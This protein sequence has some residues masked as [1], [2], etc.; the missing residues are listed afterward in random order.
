MRSRSS[1]TVYN[2]DEKLLKEKGIR[3]FR[4]HGRFLIHKGALR[5]PEGLRPKYGNLFMLDP[6]EAL[7]ERLHQNSEGHLDPT[8]LRRLQEF[9][10]RV[11]PFV[12]RFQLLRDKK[13]LFAPYV[14][15]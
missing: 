8:I 7:R 14:I 15:V 11:N 1:R 4:I 2:I 9:L 3:V 12:Q 10:Y 6:E 13:E 5:P